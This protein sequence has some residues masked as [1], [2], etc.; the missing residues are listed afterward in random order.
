MKFKLYY[1]DTIPVMDV[2]AETKEQAWKI[3]KKAG[4]RNQ[5][6]RLQLRKDEYY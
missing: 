2:I 4:I 5:S 6:K 3:I 1:K